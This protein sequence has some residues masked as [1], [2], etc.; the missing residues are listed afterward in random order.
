MKFKIF[1]ILILTYSCANNSINYNSK[2]ISHSSKGFAYIYTDED[3]ENKNVSRR[4][5]NELMQLSSN[6]VRRGALIK[7]INPENNKNVIIKNT[8]YSNYPDFYNVLITKPIALKL[9]LNENIP[10]VEVIEIKKNKSF[11]AKKAKTF[12][13]EKRV[14]K[15]APVQEVSIANISKNKSKYKNIKKKKEIFH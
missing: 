7:I 3:F 6:Y 10:Y 1:I 9:N 5:D 4:F 2:K 11:K 13:E 12:I 8:K 14:S 15:K